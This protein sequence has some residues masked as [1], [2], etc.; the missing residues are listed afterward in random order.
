[1]TAPPPDPPVRLTVADGVAT[2]T[3][4][5][6]ATKNALTP[7]H[8]SEL[9]AAVAAVAASEARVLV[10]TGAGGD[11][12]A[13]AD[14]GSGA[15]E[16]RH[17]LDRMDRITAPLIALHELPIPVL[18]AVDGVA[19]GAGWSLALCADFVVA[20]RRSRFSQIF[21]R[22]GL[23]LDTGTSWL[24][25]RL[26]GLHTAKRL[27]YF[28]EMLSAGEAYE[29]GLVTWLV[30]D[31]EMDD[32]VARLTRELAAAPP[33]ALRLD[34]ALLDHAHQRT[35]REAVAAENVAQLVNFATDAPAAKAAFTAGTAVTFS[36]RWQL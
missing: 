25:P 19:V 34:K 10:V 15:G 33:V 14:L 32:T 5:R 29:L 35:F 1:M 31:G 22:R 11:F 16:E 9:G 24:L 21:A 30:G 7:D 17:P 26:V 2:I 6:P 27:V 12:C 28:A 20:T 3:L 4:D 13:G 23:S 18:A 36:G 8:W